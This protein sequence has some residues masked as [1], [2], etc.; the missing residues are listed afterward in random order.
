VR[1]S[2]PASS[3]LRH[4][5]QFDAVY[6]RCHR[7]GDSFFSVVSR[8]NDAAGP[9]LGLAVAVKV[10]GNAV[11]RNRIR[12]LIRESFRLHRHELPAV[13]LIVS[14]RA[15]ARAAQAP[16]LRASLEALWTKVTEQCA[17]L[18]RA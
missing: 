17:S 13:D 11:R 1:L 10:A 4:K 15:A 7:L 3:R 8:L 5:S 9:R 12:R 6:A 14:V 16:V 18:P 2:F